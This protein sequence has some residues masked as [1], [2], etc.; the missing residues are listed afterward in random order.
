LNDPLSVPRSDEAKEE[1]A[2]PLS[3]GP[4]SSDPPGNP[5]SPPIDLPGVAGTP[6][7][8]D[9]AELPGPEPGKFGKPPLGEN[10]GLKLG[11]V[12]PGAGFCALAGAMLN[13]SASVSNAAGKIHV[14]RALMSSLLIRIDRRRC[15]HGEWLQARFKLGGELYRRR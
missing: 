12:N 13:G 10:P 8:T 6:A 3:T 15:R 2:E 7:G 1:F 4:L 14:L 5:L 11:I 9:F